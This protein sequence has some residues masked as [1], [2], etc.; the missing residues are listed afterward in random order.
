MYSKI[1][2]I[3]SFYSKLAI[4]ILNYNS[5][6]YVINQLNSLSSEGVSKDCFYVVDN[7]SIDNKILINFCN[8]NNFCFIQ[9]K[10]NGGYANGNNLAIKKA[11]DDNKSY[12]LLLNPDIEISKYTISVLLET[13]CNNP[14]I[15]VIGPR[16][17]DKFESNIIYSDGG[18]LFP[19]KGFEG[20][21]VH[22]YKKI[23]EIPSFGINFN[24]DYVN[25]SAILFSLH[26]L[27]SNGFMREDFFMYYEESEWCYRLKLKSQFK[28]AINTDVVAY[29]EMSDKGKFY[30]YYMTRNQIWMTRL[31]NGNS[32][33]LIRY[34]WKIIRKSI[35]KFQFN[36][37]KAVYNGWFAKIN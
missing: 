4:I 8:T 14:N 15:G 20:D 25:G 24:I 31:Y 13:I 26:A 36:I 3:D 37:L 30:Q 29:H 34:N 7:Q 35:K 11:I 6:H 9:N 12:F 23:E 21:H 32:L 5:S 2:E 1:L 19:E 16:I 28:L 22:C 33:F 18:L 27:Q 17:L 10:I